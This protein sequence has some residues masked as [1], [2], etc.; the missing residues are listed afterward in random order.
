M[1]LHAIGARSVLFY[2]IPRTNVGVWE[3]NRSHQRCSKSEWELVSKCIEDFSQLLRSLGSST[4]WVRIL[5]VMILILRNTSGMRWDTLSL[6]R[7]RHSNFSLYIRHRGS[8]VISVR[9]I[10][11]H[12]GYEI[13]LSWDIH[14]FSIYYRIALYKILAVAVHGSNSIEMGHTHFKL[15]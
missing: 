2:R 9:Y 3:T 11:K 15:S 10:A 4:K 14:N 12:C 5:C 8:Y 7:H 1:I 6:W 13:E